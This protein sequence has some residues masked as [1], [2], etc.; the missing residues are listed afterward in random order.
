MLEDRELKAIKKAMYAFY[1][2]PPPEVDEHKVLEWA[3]DARINAGLLDGVIR[4]YLAVGIKDGEMHFRVTPK[5]GK[6][7]DEL[8]KRAAGAG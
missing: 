1:G 5:G 8:L 3:I 6:K 4:G 7:V 2:G